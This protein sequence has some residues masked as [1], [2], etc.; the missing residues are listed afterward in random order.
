MFRGS[1]GQTL[2]FRF[3]R[4]VTSLL[5]RADVPI[6]NRVKR[7]RVNDLWTKR[8]DIAE[9]FMKAAIDKGPLT[10]LLDEAERSLDL[11]AQLQVWRLIRAFSKE[12]QFIV[13][14]HSFYALGLPNTNYIGLDEGYLEKSLAAFAALPGW[15]AEDP[16]PPSRERIEAMRAGGPKKE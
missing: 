3:D 14:S 9:A 16:H 2:M 6:E 12:A 4:V 15:A 8:L 10:V 7:D 11:P 1:A 13:A 5:E